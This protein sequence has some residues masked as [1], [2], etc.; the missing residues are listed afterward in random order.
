M[1]F[2]AKVRYASPRSCDT[3]H[4]PARLLRAPQELLKAGLSLSDLVAQGLEMEALAMGA[5]LE[6]VRAA[7]GVVPS[8]DDMKAAFSLGPLS[9]LTSPGQL[10]S[11]GKVI[12]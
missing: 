11:E 3:G 10:K 1:G 12:F 9:F 2:S 6:E 4:A 8:E 5:P 7:S